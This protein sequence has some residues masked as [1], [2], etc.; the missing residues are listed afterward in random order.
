MLSGSKELIC[1][2]PQEP[3]TGAPHPSHDR[4]DMVP[5]AHSKMIFFAA[6]IA[7]SFLIFPFF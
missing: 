5:H 3:H 1:L 7:F 4:S 6:S 2:V